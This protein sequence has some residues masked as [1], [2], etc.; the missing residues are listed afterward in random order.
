MFAI[1]SLRRFIIIRVK[2]EKEL[3][4][5]LCN[6]QVS[7]AWTPREN[8][9]GITGGIGAGK[10][11][12]A[13][14]L[15]ILG[16]PVYD[17]DMEAKHLMDSDVSLKEEIALRLGRGCVF[18]DGSLCRE[19]IADV[20]FSD[21]EARLWLNSRVH[22]AVY[23]E[24]ERFSEANSEKTAFVESAI[25]R[26]SGLWRLCSSVWVVTAPEDIRVKRVEERSK[27]SPEKIRERIESQ[28]SEFHF[29]GLLPEE[30]IVMISNAPSDPVL[31]H[32]LNK[33]KSLL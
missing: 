30:A 25:L 23:E 6:H 26:T 15:R 22:K 20:I 11:V 16:F 31:D 21:N 18:A 1:D 4:K 7:D 24:V 9:V 3:L 12:V 14:V 17:C 5:S 32:L 10:S 29:S 8:L 28:K 13:R 27:L 2:M 19:A 33:T